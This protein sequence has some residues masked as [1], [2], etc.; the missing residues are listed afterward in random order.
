MSP[1]QRIFMTVMLS[2]KMVRFDEIQILLLMLCRLLSVLK[3]LE[4]L[5]I[6]DYFI[7]THLGQC[8]V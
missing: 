2:L 7:H 8:L 5:M 6:S 1:L 4:S 3:S